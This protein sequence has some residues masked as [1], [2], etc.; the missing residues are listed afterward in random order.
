[1]K[2][3]SSPAFAVTLPRRMK[4]TIEETSDPVEKFTKLAAEPGGVQA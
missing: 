2:V 1:V 4:L 3:P